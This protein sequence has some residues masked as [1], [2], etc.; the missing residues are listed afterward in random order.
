MRSSWSSLSSAISRSATTGFLSLS[1]SIVIWPPAEMSRARWAA[2]R[3]ARNGWA[4]F[5]D[6]V[7]DGNA[8]HATTS[9]LRENRVYTRGQKASE[10]C[11]GLREKCSIQ[12]LSGSMLSRIAYLRPSPWALVRSG[13]PAAPRQVL[14]RPERVSPVRREIGQRNS[15]KARPSS[16]DEAGS[17]V[18]GRRRRFRHAK[19]RRSSRSAGRLAHRPGSCQMP[20]RSHAARTATSGG[21]S[22]ATSATALTYQRLVRGRT[23]AVRY[24]GEPAPS[25]R[26]AVRARPSAASRVRRAARSDRAA[27]CPQPDEDRDMH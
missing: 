26:P 27:S 4:P 21:R 6:A 11:N 1:R 22:D 23:G 7:F 17:P 10:P 12:Y 16:A 5:Q 9:E 2:S 19:S 18:P 15:T 3:P 20:P 8:G 25:A 24:Q 14:R 13:R